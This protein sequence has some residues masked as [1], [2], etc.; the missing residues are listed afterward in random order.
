VKRRMRPRRTRR[1]ES[2]SNEV[3]TEWDGRMDELRIRYEESKASL[4]SLWE[5]YFITMPQTVQ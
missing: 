4:A 3:G 2:R 5:Y 1:G